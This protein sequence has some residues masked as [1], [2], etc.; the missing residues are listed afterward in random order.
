MAISQTTI[1]GEFSDAKGAPAK[2]TGVTFALK[3]SDYEDGKMIVLKPVQAEIVDPDA[4]SF[5]ATLWPNDRGVSGNTVYS[6]TFTFEDGSKVSGIGDIR[7]EY[8]DTPVS[9]EE[10][11]VRSRL[12]KAVKPYDLRIML[13]SEFDALAEK[14]PNTIY[15]IKAG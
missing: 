5:T 13:Q 6:V 4:G 3:G 14:A 10:I 9:L 7:V 15:L 1:I 12:S 8:S 11:E 2:L